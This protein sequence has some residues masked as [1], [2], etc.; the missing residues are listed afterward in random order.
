MASSSADEAAPLTD[1]QLSYFRTF[2]FLHLKGVFTR[3][4]SAML[5]GRADELAAKSTLV[6]GEF[7]PRGPKGDAQ[8]YVMEP[9]IDRPHV[10]G[11]VTSGPCPLSLRPASVRVGGLLPHHHQLRECRHCFACPESAW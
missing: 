4:D 11:A 6:A 2:G 10:L 3:A 5:T 7:Q 8:P 9:V 1:A